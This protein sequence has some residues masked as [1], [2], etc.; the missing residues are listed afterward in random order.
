MQNAICGICYGFTYHD[1]FCKEII[2]SFDRPRASGVQLASGS[3]HPVITRANFQSAG[4]NENNYLL[5]SRD[6]FLSFG[7]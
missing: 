7:H 6:R 4:K 2:T 1:V 3:M 5:K